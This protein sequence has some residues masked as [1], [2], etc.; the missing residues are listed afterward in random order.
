MAC[1]GGAR[2][3]ASDKGDGADDDEVAPQAPPLKYGDGVLGAGVADGV[4]VTEELPLRS[5]SANK[6]R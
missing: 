1:G 6:V 3:P 4:D 2:D 5:R